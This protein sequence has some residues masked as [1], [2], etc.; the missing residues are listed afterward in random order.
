MGDRHGRDADDEDVERARGEGLNGVGAGIELGELEVEAGL[1]RR[2]VTG[3]DEEGAR[4]DHRDIADPN[5]HGLRRPTPGAARRRRSPER[6]KSCGPAWRTPHQPSAEKPPRSLVVMASRSWRWL[7]NTAVRGDESNRLSSFRGRSSFLLTAHSTYEPAPKPP[8]GRC[9]GFRAWA[10][11]EGR[12]GSGAASQSTAAV[13]RSK[14]SRCVEQRPGRYPNPARGR[15]MVRR[16]C[17]SPSWTRSLTSPA[18]RPSEPFR[19]SRPRR[20]NA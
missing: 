14:S 1:A 4:P 2:T 3:E 8:S 10:C 19:S 20:R 5:R 13:P 17:L 16:R 9:R 12:V 7:L 6:E 18:G 15:F 11:P